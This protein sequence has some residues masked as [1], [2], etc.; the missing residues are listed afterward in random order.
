MSA[1]PSSAADPMVGLA[2]EFAERYRR[3]ERPALTEYTDRHP[4]L[5]ERIRR[6]FPT[7]VVMEEFG[8]VAGPD[9]VPPAGCEAPPRQLGEYRILRE[10][11]RGG[12]GVVY[13]AVQ[14][15]LGRHV[16][17]KVLPGG[18]RKS[19]VHVERFR[20]EARAVARLHH[21]NIVPVF[22]VGEAGGVHYYAMQFIRGQS[23]DSVL[24][25]LKRLGRGWTDPAGGPPPA[26]D[27][28]RHTALGTD[29]ARGLMTGEFPGS[30]APTVT[31]LPDAPAGSVT[32]P[33]A[34]PGGDRAAASGGSD[35]SELTRRSDA[36]YARGVARVGVQA[37]EA[38][39]YAHGQG[40]L[41]RDI[42]P[43]NLLL[44]TRGTVWVTDFGLAKTAG[45][46]ELTGA[47]DIVGTL[48]YMAPER[49]RGE[50]DPRSDVYGLG[51]TL[52]EMLTLRPAFDDADRPRLM[53]S[54]ARSNPRAPRA[55]NPHVPR[56]L[57][58]IVLKAIAKDPAHRYA[59][60]AAM[61]EDLG[62]F[63]R[64][65]PILARRTTWVEHGA[66]WCRR[67]PAVAG[68]LTVVA[69]L[70][71][72]MVVVLAVTN[73]RIS[74]ALEQEKQARDLLEQSLY[75]QW[76]AA[77]AD[78]RDQHHNARSEEFLGRC[79]PRLRG[80]EW[81]YLKRRPFAT[82]PV[83]THGDSVIQA[84]AYTPDGRLSAVGDRNGLV[85]VRDARSGREV[86]A[87]FRATAEFVRGLAFSPDGRYLATGG[88]DD[89]VKL[90]DPRTGEL[91]REF[92]TGGRVVLLALKFSP[93][94]RRLAASDQDRGIHVWD[95][96]SADRPP[97]L[98]SAD[99]LAIGGLEFSADGRLLAVSTEGKVTAWDITTREPTPL[100]DAQFHGVH[101]VAFS[102]DRRLIALGSEAGLVRVLRSDPWVV[103]WSLE[104]HTGP[105]HGLAF[106][107]GGDRLATCT[108]NMTV[109]LWDMGT[110]QE[111]LSANFAGHSWSALAFTPD[112]HRLA[113]GTIDGT[114]RVLDGT[115]LDG[116]GDGGQVL[117][118]EAHRHTVVGL[119]Y[120]PDGGRIATASWD[121]A[122]VFD[123]RSGRELLSL[124]V[125]DAQLT[126]IAFSRGGRLVATSGW[127][128][129]VCVFDAQTGAELYP[130]LRGHQAGPVYGVTFDPEDRSLVSAHH[131]GT[132]RVWDV[133]SGRPRRVVQAHV[134]PVLG[135]AFSPDGKF[136][137]T[138]GGKEHTATVWEWGP[139]SQQAVL[140]LRMPASGI[141]RSPAF[142]PDGRRVVAVTGPSRTVWTWDLVPGKRD[143]GDGKPFVIPG[144]GKINQATFY[145]D[146][147]R[148]VVVSDAQVQL[149]DP[150]TGEVEAVP[151]AHAG[152]IGCA[153]VSPDGQFLATGAGYRGRGEVRIWELARWDQKP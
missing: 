124:P 92:S 61:A 121:G 120:S 68:L 91:V 76:V 5:A 9:S 89:R 15:S 36:E 1:D 73:A 7:L 103:L 114:V 29:I 43:S 83:Q 113:A 134:H 41:H 90:W 49:F 105:V 126:G 17:L 35:R 60:A 116:P 112:G 127:D 10:V 97:P 69:S 11:G 13:E 38:L 3:G 106:G 47:G 46:D 26:R 12:M 142:S 110:G 108:V 143:V 152:D 145:P 6:L 146:G 84:M 104:A 93:D 64:D 22:G 24:E 88:H 82:I 14:E 55:I 58:T 70:L 32:A 141:L 39:A 122:G 150:E 130:P 54:I 80:W 109:R 138:S 79:P 59:S 95:V 31:Y 86:L 50:S 81:H 62:R 51:L 63:L 153:V 100:F 123:A 148:V 45:G 65:R 99:R 87:P 23:L 67:N 25:E 111:A 21:T 115:P 119:A 40:V 75:Y 107:A 136:L 129:V 96:G 52:Y 44:D 118:M 33:F 30:D 147:R 28:E 137:V 151:A 133:E 132:V 72:G 131:D 140:T 2:E 4:E 98:V 53:D 117:T 66:R 71:V 74:G 57:E 27:G 20:R 102:A 125:G 85:A 78:A 42:K 139:E 37:A 135:L 149:L 101:S 77:A 19:P 94:G 56:D 48:R 34:H 144:T 128:G 8:S 18:N 16:A